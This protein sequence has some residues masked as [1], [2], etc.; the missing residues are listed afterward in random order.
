M[1]EHVA[2][3]STEPNGWRPTRIEASAGQVARDTFHHVA[4]L[5]ATHLGPEDRAVATATTFWQIGD[6]AGDLPLTLVDLAAGLELLVSPRVFAESPTTTARRNT[7]D[8]IAALILRVCIGDPQRLAAVFRVVAARCEGAP[9]P[10][11]AAL[12]AIAAREAAELETV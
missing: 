8:E 4:E 5:I 11:H 12:G 1:R 9:D 7:Y 3:D 10:K 2:A 6:L